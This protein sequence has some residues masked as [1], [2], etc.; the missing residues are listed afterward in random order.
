[1]SSSSLDL[2]ESSRFSNSL[3]LS[4]LKSLIEKG[5]K[6]S[7]TQKRISIGAAVFVTLSYFF[8]KKIS[9]PPKKIRHIPSVNYAQMMKAYITG[10]PLNKIVKRIVSPVI[11][12]KG[13]YLVI[14]L[15]AFFLG[16]QKC[17]VFFQ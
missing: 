10:E 11:N 17:F 7:K 5:Q 12:P 3:I 2:F 15:H 13:L 1:M 16:K 6:L 14:M 9:T 8:F 4:S